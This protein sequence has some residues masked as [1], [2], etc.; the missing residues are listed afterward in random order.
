M[1]VLFKSPY[2]RKTV[3]GWTGH[4]VTF[5]WTFSGAVD[6][7]TW[8]IKEAGANAI[9][10]KN[11]LL[12]VIDKRGVVEL[13][14]QSVPNAYKSRVSGNRTGDSSSGQASFTLSNITKDDE[15]FYGCS[16][17]PDDPNQGPEVD[18]VHLILVGMYLNERVQ[19]RE[20]PF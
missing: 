9:D 4:S 11:G 8:G 3:T 16:I 20:C 10:Y 17:K 2:Q 12:V 6:T 15:R 13:S 19:R 5:T 7:V 18:F 1:Q 14:S